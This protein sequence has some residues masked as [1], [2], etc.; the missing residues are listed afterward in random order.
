MCLVL[1]LLSL[2]QNDHSIRIVTIPVRKS[3]RLEVSKATFESNGVYQCIVSND[4]GSVM[5]SFVVEVIQGQ[6]PEI[7]FVI[8]W[9]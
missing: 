8:T 9:A 7:R 4:A 3:S 6:S 5:H 1:I 2:S